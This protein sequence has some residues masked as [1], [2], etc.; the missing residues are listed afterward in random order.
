M[1]VTELGDAFNK[2]IQQYLNDG[3]NAHLVHVGRHEQISK[4]SAVNFLWNLKF[5]QIERFKFAQ[6]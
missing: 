1:F 5:P 3:L 4:P 6:L 2:K